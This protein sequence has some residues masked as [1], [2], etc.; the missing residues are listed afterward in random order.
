MNEIVKLNNIKVNVEANSWEDSIRKAGE[1]LVNSNS[2][3]NKYIEDMIDSVKRLGPYIVL[4]PGFA[5]GHSE[6]CADVIK[7]DISL[8]TLSNPV[9]FGSPNDPVSIVMCLACVDKESHMNNIQLLATKLMDENAV[10]DMM[11]C[12]TNQELY[13]FIN[14]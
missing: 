10:K 9:S 14:K 7:T 8:I 12:K 4:M 6:P 2:I 5:L 1:L 13:E 3:T 11:A